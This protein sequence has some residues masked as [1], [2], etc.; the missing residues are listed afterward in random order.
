[1]STKAYAGCPCWRPSKHSPWGTII[2]WRPIVPSA[3]LGDSS[4][5][6]RDAVTESAV[7]EFPSALPTRRTADGSWQ[8]VV[9]DVAVPVTN[10]EKPYWSLEGYTKGD[11]L[12][13]YYNIASYVL[14]YVRDRPLTC[15]RMPHGAD[16]EFFYMK[17][18]PPHTPEWVTTARVRSLDSDKAIDYLQAQDVASLLWIANLGCIELHPWHARSDA[19]GRPDYALFDLD[20]FHVPFS[21]VREVAL[22]VRTAVERLGLRAYPRTSGAT[23]M[24]VLVPIDR[25]H[26]AAA[27]RQFV[28]RVCRIIHRA[29]PD[30][31]TMEWS[32]ADR[33]GRVFL[34]YGMNT[35]GKNISAA[36]S[37]RPERGAPVAAPLTWDEVAQD[38]EPADFTIASIWPRLEAVGDLHAPVLQGGQDLRKAMRTVGMDPDVEEPPGHEVVGGGERGDALARYRQRRNFTRTPEPP[39]EPEPRSAPVPEAADAPCKE[40]PAEPSAEPEGAMPPTRAGTGEVSGRF[41]IQHHLAARL[42][43]DLRLEREGSA[44]SWAV[45]KG[46]PDVPGLRHLAVQTEDHP[47]EYLTFSGEIPRG[48]YGAGPVRIWDEGTYECLEWREDKVSFRLRGGRHDGEFRLV[49]TDGDDP[50]QWL[51]LRVGDPEA[52]PDEPPKLRPMLAVDG[53]KAFDDPAW[54]FELKWDGVR[55]IATVARPGGR[56]SAGTTLTSRAGNDVTA[57]Y[58]E[59]E[60][61]WERVLARNAVLDGEIVALD[62]Q[63]RPSFQRLQRRMHLRERS[64]VERVRRQ[65]PVSYMV[66][67]LLFVDGESLLDRPLSERLQRL[68]EVL[69]TGG[70]IS[71]SEGVTEA[72]SALYRM[73][74]D[75]G[76]EG[77]IGKRLASVYRPGKRSDDWRKLKVRRRA[78]VVIGGWM[79]GERA[80][81][82]YLGSLLV[83]AFDGDRLRYVGRVGTGFD[84]SELDRLRE[85]LAARATDACPFDT[86]SELPRTARWVTADLV[87]RT[88]Y[89]E[90]TDEGVLRAPAY[91]GLL[92]DVDPR[93]CDFVA[94]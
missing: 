51:V 72:G 11:L 82:G 46:L 90:L 24:Q 39:P 29:D 91:K 75:H 40:A 34:D 45:P 1:M 73:A 12:S 58:P 21:T 17:Q 18:A 8:V 85:L 89:A 57:A 77:V 86:G 43:H 78:D 20:P 56:A 15:K 52:L 92:T 38:V 84:E 19:I 59:I 30:R 16:G 65:V 13:Y 50:S 53:G 94:L 25:V 6:A 55:T 2:G 26:S 80:R 5:V 23:G 48:E 42:H 33:T 81:A 83:G 7:I 71:R 87:C 27:V 62:R 4:E 3:R 60:S 88:E 54:R 63:G 44:P 67:D 74:R 28:G 47:L 68:D 31:T 36:Y 37:L 64:A 93:E 79:P 76:M 69:V 14:P 49:R 61:L 70:S 35:E 66:F 10:L 41:V 9:D 32:I 22:L